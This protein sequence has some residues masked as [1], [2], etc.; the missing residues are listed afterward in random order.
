MSEEHWIDSVAAKAGVSP[1]EAITIIQAMLE[2]PLTTAIVNAGLYRQSVQNSGDPRGLFLPRGLQVA[3]IG[4]LDHA[5]IRW[6]KT[7]EP[8]GFEL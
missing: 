2:T 1:Q 8:P 4:I 7:N 6:R 3:F 5:L